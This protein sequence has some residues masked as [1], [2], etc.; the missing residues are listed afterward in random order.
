M[1]EA[2][3][4]NLN[5]KIVEFDDLVGWTIQ[6]LKDRELR[7]Y[8]DLCRF[9]L[10]WPEIEG[11]IRLNS[12]MKGRYFDQTPE[13]MI[14]VDE[15]DLRKHFALSAEIDERLIVDVSMMVGE[16]SQRQADMNAYI[17]VVRNV[18]EER[19]ASILYL[20][21]RSKNVIE[22]KRDLALAQ[23]GLS[24]SLDTRSMLTSLIGDLVQDI[25]S[26]LRYKAR[27]ESPVEFPEA[28]SLD[29]LLLP[30]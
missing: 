3:Q 27:C 11:S 6:L 2:L 19:E 8:R 16:D 22:V 5:K 13:Q 10:R 26:L 15:S 9:A 24:R 25:R 1:H 30:R 28:P 7:A 18:R 12:H 23:L 17:S 4:Q 29:Q 20:H 14:M 21:R